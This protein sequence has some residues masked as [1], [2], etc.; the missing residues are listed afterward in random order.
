M[1]TLTYASP[2]S[3]DDTPAQEGGGQYRYKHDYRPSE[4]LEAAHVSQGQTNVHDGSADLRDKC[5]KFFSLIYFLLHWRFHSPFSLNFPS[6]EEKNNKIK[7]IQ[8]SL[9][10]CEINARQMTLIYIFLNALLLFDSLI[11]YQR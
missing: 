9:S 4:H 8:T 1:S 11:P 2:F 3:P 10:F 5:F 7:N 6:I